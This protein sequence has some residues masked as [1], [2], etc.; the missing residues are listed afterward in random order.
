LDEVVPPPINLSSVLKKA[1]FRLL[2]KA[3]EE[4]AFHEDHMSLDILKEGGGCPGKHEI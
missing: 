2:N 4:V 3:D 1:T